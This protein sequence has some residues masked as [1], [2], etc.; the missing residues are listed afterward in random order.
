MTG[1]V[2]ERAKEKRKIGSR[3]P[4]TAP[5]PIALGKESQFPSERW[6]SA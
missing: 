4:V 3:G 2:R 5:R 6:G 1:G